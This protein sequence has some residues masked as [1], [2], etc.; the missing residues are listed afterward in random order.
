[1]FELRDYI[2]T[3][4]GSRPETN[5]LDK[6]I[7]RKHPLNAFGLLRGGDVFERTGAV[8]SRDAPE[9]LVFAAGLHVEGNGAEAGVVSFV[10]AEVIGLLR[11]NGRLAARMLES[12]KLRVDI[13]KPGSAFTDLGLPRA[14]SNHVAGVF[15][16]DEGWPCARIVVRRECLPNTPALVAHELAHALFYVAFTKIERDL[17]YASLS[18]TFGAR[19]S[20]DEAFAIYSERE[21]QTAFTDDDKKVSGIYGKIRSAWSD[22]HVF[23]RFIRKLY[24]PSKPLAGPRMAKL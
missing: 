15:W 24:F 14:M 1:M 4:D 11:G 22:D 20:M 6:A 16:D 3:R 19:A 10:R 12:K 7:A 2:E 18:R 21:V 5:G 17:V 9:A 13:A 23:T 8:S